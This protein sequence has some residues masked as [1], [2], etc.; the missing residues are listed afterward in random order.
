MARFNHINR[1]KESTMLI[2]ERA[3]RYYT[4][5]GYRT[6]K[7]G[8][9]IVM[10]SPSNEDKIF[11]G[12]AGAIRTG[13][14]V[15]ESRSITDLAMQKIIEFETFFKVR[16]LIGIKQPTGINFSVGYLYLEDL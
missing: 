9:Y 4:A 2:W 13:K 6:L 16:Q 12:K 5:K 1:Q 7:E 15:T 3:V 11:I 14:N 10:E 8:K